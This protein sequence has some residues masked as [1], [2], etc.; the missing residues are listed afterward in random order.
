MNSSGCSTIC[1]MEDLDT[2]SPKRVVSFTNWFDYFPKWAQ[3]TDCVILSGV[4][5]T[6]TLHRDPFTGTSVC[7]EGTKI[8]RFIEPP[9]KPKDV[10]TID[11]MM[12]SYRLPSMAWNGNTTISAGWQSDFSL[13]RNICLDNSGDTSN[14]S[15]EELS[16]IP[17]TREEKYNEILQL[18]QSL[19]SLQL[20]DSLLIGLNCT[21]IWTTVQQEGD[22]LIILAHCWHQAYT[23]L[24][25]TVT[26]S[27]HHCSDFDLYRVLN[28]IVTTTT[29]TTNQTFILDIEDLV[30]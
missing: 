28:H 29:T 6:S 25:P 19:D 5:S 8:W 24:E 20:D 12:Q 1:D 15:I 26:I 30:V 7:V 3:S 10:H 23:I 21:T 9:Q 2:T 13:Y 27:S 17:T 4:G 22:F 14:K 16:A 18:A 11:T